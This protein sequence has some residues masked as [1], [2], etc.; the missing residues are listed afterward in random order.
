VIRRFALLQNIE[1]TPTYKRL[2][3][4]GRI[5][6]AR[7]MLILLVQRRFPSL[8]TLARAKAENMTDLEQLQEILLEIS[9]A[10]LARDARKSLAKL[11]LEDPQQ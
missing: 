4:R 8:V 11:D 1:D 9:A 10:R 7:E 2:V 3:Q 6:E 5:E